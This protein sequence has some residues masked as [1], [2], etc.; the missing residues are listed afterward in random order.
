[1][2][3]DADT[4]EIL[5]K[6]K[7]NLPYGPAFPLLGVFPKVV[8]FYST[9]TPSAM[10]I[11]SQF[12][13]ARIWKQTN[14]PSTDEYIMKMCCTDTMEYYSAVKKNKIMKFESRWIK[15]K[16]FIL[17][18]VTCFFLSMISRFKSSDVTIQHGINAKTLKI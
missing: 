14:S 3:I 6:L 15:L 1:M 17:R 8:T 5:K 11:T 16:K 12:T 10:F 18:K 4:L 7:I 13:M 9:D 2:K